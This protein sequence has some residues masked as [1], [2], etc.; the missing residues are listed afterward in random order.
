MK[1][2][3]YNFRVSKNSLIL[4]LSSYYFITATS[5][6]TVY[7]DIYVFIKNRIKEHWASNLPKNVEKTNNAQAQV[8]CN[9]ILVFSSF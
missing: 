2:K 4:L 7:I 9:T 1:I 3:L 8:L 6:M 5:C